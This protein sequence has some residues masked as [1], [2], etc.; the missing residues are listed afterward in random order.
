MMNRQR[1]VITGASGQLGSELKDLLSGEP[2]WDCVFLGRQQLPLEQTEAIEGLLSGYAP[3]I[4]I[5]AGAYTAVDKAEEE[6][7]LADKVNHLACAEIARYCRHHQVKLIAISTDYVFDGLSEEPLNEEAPTQP[8]NR[9]GITKL[10]GEKAIQKICPDAIIIRTSWVYSSYGRN[11][12]KT[13]LRLMDEREEISVVNDQVGSPTYAADLATAIRDIL[14][15]ER[16]VPGVYH[17]S[18][19]GQLSWYDF[20]LAIKELA[21]KSC[22]VRPISS[23]EFPTLAKRPKYSLLDK[24]KIKQTFGLEVPYWKDSLQSMLAKI[25][26]QNS[27]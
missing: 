21:G 27:K 13:M 4:L 16:W 10:E 17:Y 11:F 26:S 19:E 2:L 18:N 22:V 14:K 25:N 9:Y 24:A 3:D 7:D 20:A 6:A 15:A 23:E 8:I 12:V 1:I 5:H